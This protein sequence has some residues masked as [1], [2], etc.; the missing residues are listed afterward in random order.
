MSTTREFRLPDLGEG[1][2]EA[3][4]VT[5]HV[6]PGDDVELNQVI[7]EVETAKALVDLP[8]PVAGI[9]GKLHAEAGTTVEVGEVIVTFEVPDE[10]D[11]KAAEG[12]PQAAE[13]AA[14]ATEGTQQE[15][16]RPAPEP[17]ETTAAPE[18]EAQQP[19]LVGY[20]AQDRR[21]RP[22]RRR[23]KAP[24]DVS[25][26]AAAPPPGREPS[27][28]TRS[29]RPRATPP[30]RALA[31]RLGIELEH[32]SGT[33][34]G[35]L[36]TRDDVQAASTEST[37]AGQLEPGTAATTPSPPAAAPGEHEDTDASG[38]PITRIP[39]RG[40][41]KHTAAAMVTSAFTAPHASVFL[42]VDVTDAMQ[43][44]E[45]LRARRTAARVTV[46]AL[47]ARATC[48]TLGD[49][50]MLRSRWDEEAGE[51]VRSHHTDL[52]IAVASDRGLLVPVIR[53]A[54]TLGLDALAEAL[55]AR[56]TEA[57]EGRTPPAAMSSGTMTITN[58][59]ALGVDGG[60]P[61]LNPGEPAI[62]ALGAVRRQPWEYEDGI[63]LRNVTTLSMSFDHRVVDGEQAANFLADLGALLSNPALALTYGAP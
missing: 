7:A 6:Q 62:L 22:K 35:G 23:R 43:L 32:V 28:D 33:G 49:H 41:R 53:N 54:H 18:D 11:T 3:D 21:G 2:T 26:P 19:N 30:V 20:G 24:R 8:S 5:W 56:V 29:L 4:I 50:P 14:Q 51:I 46:L 63:A 9:I 25:S 59:G 13:S 12:A 34:E 17:A 55:A 52:G 44:L 38:R 45:D 60:T 10:D 58:V 31:R 48:L 1:L 39:I 27:Q 42:T 15:T 47:V 16:E 37:S 40:V 57:R 61:I 36:I